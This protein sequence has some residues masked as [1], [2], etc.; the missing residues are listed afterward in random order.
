MP[1]WLTIVIGRN[2]E[3][4]VDDDADDAVQDPGCTRADDTERRVLCYVRSLLYVDHQK[5]ISDVINFRRLYRV[6]VEPT[7]EGE[8]KRRIV[9]LDERV[10][11]KQAP[12]HLNH[13]PIQPKATQ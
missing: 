3:W 12:I 7:A 4:D 13:L 2:G 6:E 11:D 1:E 5:H 10:E 9:S 8:D